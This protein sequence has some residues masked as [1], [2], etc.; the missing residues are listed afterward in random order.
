MLHTASAWRGVD[1][2]FDTDDAAAS[3]S[4]CY[5]FSEEN[6]VMRSKTGTCSCCL[7]DVGFSSGRAAWEFKLEKDKENDEGT[8]FGASL[9]PVSSRQYNG[10]SNL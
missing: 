10:S 7:V 5:Q 6:Q 9:K 3:G 2:Y 1:A 4:D 8:T